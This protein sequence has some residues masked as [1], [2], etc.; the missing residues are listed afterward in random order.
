MPSLTRSLT[1]DETARQV[2]DVL[3]N[4]L[5]LSH[6]PE[7]VLETVYDPVFGPSFVPV[8]FK[9]DPLSPTQLAKARALLKPL[10]L[11]MTQA[12]LKACYDRLRLG[13]AGNR[14]SPNEEKT[15]Q[16]LFCG[17]LQAYPPCVVRQAV[18]YPF[19]FF[20]SLGELTEVCQ[21]ENRYLSVLKDAF[22]KN[23]SEPVKGALL[24]DA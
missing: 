13:A 11:P 10:F 20:P 3:K 19:K 7:F 18:A 1:P 17:M 21:G 22:F 12:E 9:T 2:A 14:L 23:E 15:R 16:T 8:G 24:H 4:Y 6:T 5:N